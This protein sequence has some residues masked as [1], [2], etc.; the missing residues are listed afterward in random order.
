[1]ETRLLDDLKAVYLRDH[2]HMKD[3]LAA[4]RREAD[5]LRDENRRLWQAVGKLR[6]AY[7]ILWAVAEPENQVE[8]DE[9]AG[10]VGQAAE[11][12]SR[13]VTLAEA[14]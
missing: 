8:M 4:S 14:N 13:L 12:L 1:M 10:L 6:A 7:G 11:E 5:E 2:T 9:A 3:L